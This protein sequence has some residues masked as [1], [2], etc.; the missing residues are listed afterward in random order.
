MTHAL[1]RRR[2]LRGEL[3]D[4]EA[5]IMRPPGAQPRFPSLCDSC[6]ACA[7]ACPEAIIIPSAHGGPQIDFA[8]GACT[9]CGACARACPTGALAEEP[10]GAPPPWPWRARIEPACLSLQ[11]VACRACEDACEPRAIR[12]RPQV[13]G[14]AKPAIDMNQCTGC[15]ECAFTCPA[16]AIAFERLPTQSSETPS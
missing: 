9:F 14:A 10:E 1:D 3:H 13:G 8:R 4:R 2:L 7:R 16:K 12:F 11:G 15:G 5:A 6:G